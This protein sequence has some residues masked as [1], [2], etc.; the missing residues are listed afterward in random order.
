MQQL[1]LVRA[2]SGGVYLYPLICGP[3]SPLERFRMR[4]RCTG[5][6]FVTFLHKYD[7]LLCIEKIKTVEILVCVL[8]G[9]NMTLRHFSAPQGRRVTFQHPGEPSDIIWE[10]LKCT[11]RDRVARTVGFACW[12]TL[13]FAHYSSPGWCYIGVPRPQPFLQVRIE[14]FSHARMLTPLFNSAVIAF[15]SD[16]QVRLA[17]SKE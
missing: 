16:P 12:G 8:D 2:C 11:S 6:A 15:V 14:L 4:A 3:W 9:C 17:L 10:N 7:A 5:H 1:A 13:T